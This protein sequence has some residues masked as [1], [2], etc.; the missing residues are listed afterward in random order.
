MASCLAKE[1]S[2]SLFNVKKDGSSKNKERVYKY[3]Y[4]YRYLDNYTSPSTPTK[5]SF[6]L[7]L[8]EVTLVNECYNIDSVMDCQ[9]RD[10]CSA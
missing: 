8:P 9:G 5:K 2:Q 6:H 10:R 7:T 3:L 1:A 4:K